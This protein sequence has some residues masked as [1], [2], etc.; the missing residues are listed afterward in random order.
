[1]SKI[2]AG[3]TFEDEIG[4]PVK[5]ASCEGATFNVVDED[6][7]PAPGPWTAKRIRA[8]VAA[9]SVRER[10]IAQRIEDAREARVRWLNRDRSDW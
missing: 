5:V 10:E 1:M 2:E 3:M 7:S 4:R 8:C 9:Q 6:G